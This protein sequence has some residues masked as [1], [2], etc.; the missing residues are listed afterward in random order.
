[1]LGSDIAKMFIQ[2]CLNV[3]SASVF[4]TREQSCHN[5]HTMLPEQCLNVSP[6][7]WEVALLLC[8]HNIAHCYNIGQCFGNV[9]ILF[10]I[11]H[12]Y[13]VGALAGKMT[14]SCSMETEKVTKSTSSVNRLCIWYRLRDNISRCHVHAQS[15]TLV[16]Q[17]TCIYN[18][19]SRRNDGHSVSVSICYILF[20]IIP[21]MDVFQNERLRM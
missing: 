15:L 2:H 1:M 3:F 18:Q 11:Q 14:S 8:S 7:H 16:S 19:Y 17:G 9:G 20:W 21:N 10:K 6:Q 4:H 5:V 12:W 13:N